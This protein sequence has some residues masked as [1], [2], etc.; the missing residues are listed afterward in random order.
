ME[1][2]CYLKVE[3]ANPMKNMVSFYMTD[4]SAND[5]NINMASEKIN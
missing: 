1:V 3:P 2:A 4:T 5:T